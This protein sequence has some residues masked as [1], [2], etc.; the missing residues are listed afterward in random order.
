MLRLPLPTAPLKALFPT[1][2]LKVLLPTA[3]L[4]APLPTALLPTAPT[5]LTKMPKLE[6]DCSL[7]GQRVDSFIAENGDMTRSAAAQ[8]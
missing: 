5:E 3:L 2:P 8:W 6:L 4:K 7:G 1:T